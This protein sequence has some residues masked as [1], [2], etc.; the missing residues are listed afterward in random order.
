MKILGRKEKITLSELGL[1]GVGAKLDTGAYTSS[2]H[3]EEIREE[4]LEGKQV[5][6]CKILLPSHKKFTGL[7]LYFDAY[8]KKIVKNSFG[9]AES[10]YVIETRI[11]IAGESF[12]AEFT[13]TDRSSMKNSIL[14]GRKILRG[15]FLV[16]VSKTNLAKA[17]RRKK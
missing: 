5:L 13:L 11:R 10:R 12:R 6:S 1:K 4:L 9:Q 7:V 17:Y 16:D 2:L 15:R 14:L 3:A 8:K